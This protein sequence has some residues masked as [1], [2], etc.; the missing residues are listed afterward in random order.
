MIHNTQYAAGGNIETVTGTCARLARLV[1]TGVD[2]GGALVTYD[3]SENIPITFSPI[4]GTVVFA[5]SN[6]GMNYPYPDDSCTTFYF[7]S[8]RVTFAAEKDGFDVS[9]W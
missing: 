9:G 1:Y 3:I 2:N 7:G 8:G 5:Y 4:K 6:V